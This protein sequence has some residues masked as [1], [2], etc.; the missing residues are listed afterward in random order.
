MMMMKK[1]PRGFTFVELLVVIVATAVLAVGLTVVLRP[2]LDAYAI[3]RS[4]SELASA[5]TVALQR[6]ARDVAMAVPNSIRTPNSQ[7]FDVVP[8]SASGRVRMGP[9]LAAPGSAPLDASQPTMQL[10]VLTDLSPLPSAGTWLVMGNQTAGDLY[11]GLSRAA[12]ASAAAVPNSAFG[13]VRLNFSPAFQFPQGMSSGRFQLVSASQGVV[14]YVCAADTSGHS[15]W[16]ISG[17]PFVANHP[18]SCPATTGGQRIV[19]GLSACSFSYDPGPMATQQYG[20]L[21]MQFDL[22]RNGESASIVNSVQVLN[23]Q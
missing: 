3:G 19:T 23:Q 8:S 5:A 10:D 2:A 7:C 1:K 13:T 15:L 4:R 17:R 16:R 6:I 12:I 20:L 11:S 18:T 14:S 9:D 21:T 22:A